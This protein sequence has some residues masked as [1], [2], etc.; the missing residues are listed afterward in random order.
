MALR[1][2]CLVSRL[3]AVTL[4]YEFKIC[5]C[6][7]LLEL[8]AD[9]KNALERYSMIKDRHRE[10]SEHGYLLKALSTSSSNF[11][12]PATDRDVSTIKEVLR[13]AGY[14]C[15]MGTLWC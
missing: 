11:F 10:G 15:S 4:A 6:Q 7:V 1:Q 14:D 2:S 8:S 12:V 3:S 13:E 5:V 9:K